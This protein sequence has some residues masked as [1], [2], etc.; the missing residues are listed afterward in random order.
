[1]NHGLHHLRSISVSH[2][3]ALEYSQLFKFG[4]GQKNLV[5]NALPFLLGYVGVSDKPRC[6]RQNLTKLLQVNVQVEPLSLT[7]SKWHEKYKV[8]RSIRVLQH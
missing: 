2:S 1:M 6:F 8:S 7:D 3:T 5:A 4:I